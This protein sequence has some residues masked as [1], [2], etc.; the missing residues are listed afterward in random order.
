M[1]PFVGEIRM[2]AG[3]YAPVD[4]M[5]CEGQLLK[6]ADYQ[7]LYACIGNTYGGDGMTTFALPDLRCRVPLHLGGG[8]GAGQAG[9]AETVTPTVPEIPAH[10]HGFFATGNQATA[11]SAQNNVA[12]QAAAYQPYIAQP[13]N[14][15]IFPGSVSLTGGS[16]AHNNIQPYLCINFIIAMTGYF[17]SRG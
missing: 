10:S 6:I 3:T 13:A 5:F 15:A 4:W 14:L 7:V 8:F 9:G 11:A 1:D 2:F 16:Q 17:P 12:A